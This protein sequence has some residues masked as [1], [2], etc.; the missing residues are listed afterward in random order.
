MKMKQNALWENEARKKSCNRLIDT[1]NL[2]LKCVYT[3]YIRLI[4]NELL[5]ELMKSDEVD[6]YD[7]K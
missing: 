4:A 7:K 2:C 3:L 5:I 1:G 6:S